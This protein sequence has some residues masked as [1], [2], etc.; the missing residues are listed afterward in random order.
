MDVFELA[1]LKREKNL[2]RKTRALAKKGINYVPRFD[3]DALT[4]IKAAEKSIEQ[5][6]P[7]PVRAGESGD[8]APAIGSTTPPIGREGEVKISVFVRG[9]SHSCVFLIPGIAGMLPQPG[10]LRRLMLAALQTQFGK[11]IDNVNDLS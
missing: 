11:R 4:D 6:L 7:S 9:A 10:D 8:T 5:E 2:E 1:R 3:G